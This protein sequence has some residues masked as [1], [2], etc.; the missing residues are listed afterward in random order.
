MLL[1][2]TW[3]SIEAVKLTRPMV[4][5]YTSEPVTSVGERPRGEGRMYTGTPYAASD[6]E[7][8]WS[9]LSLSPPPPAVRLGALGEAPT[10]AQD[11][12]VR[13]AILPPRTAGAPGFLG[14]VVSK[15]PP[16]AVQEVK[17]LVHA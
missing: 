13:R 14:L 9:D 16:Y 8:F 15:S 3:T 5:L 2:E 10:N 4:P 6:D 11:A 1:W 17:K 7:G 12:G